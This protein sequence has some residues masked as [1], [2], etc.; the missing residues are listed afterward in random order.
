MGKRYKQGYTVRASAALA[1]AGPKKK[2]LTRLVSRYVSKR[3]TTGRPNTALGSVPSST[4]AASPAKLS[5]SIETA[6]P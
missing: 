6:S 5:A 1:P 4:L 2:L 3:T